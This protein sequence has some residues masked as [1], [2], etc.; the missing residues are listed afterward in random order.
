MREEAYT[1]ILDMIDTFKSGNNKD[2]KYLSTN[3]NFIELKNDQI[4]I[5]LKPLGN[6][7]YS[8]QGAFIKKSDNDRMAYTNLFNRPTAI[9][10]EDY[11]RQVEEYYTQYLQENGRK[12]SR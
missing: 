2:T 7:N 11:S 10:D 4:R 6:N 12:G 8:V 3:S 5:V 9:I 1:T